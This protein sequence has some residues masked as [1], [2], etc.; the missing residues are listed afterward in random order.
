MP[1]RF[2]RAWLKLARAQ[3][4]AIA[5]RQG[6]DLEHILAAK[7]RLSLLLSQKLAIY[8][9]GDQSACLVKEILAEEEAA[10]EELV[11]WREKVAEEF[12]QLQKWR[13]LIQHQ[14][15]LAPVRNRLF[16]RRC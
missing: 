9:P 7:E 4:K 12:C 1:E 14:R 16:E 6:E 11:R 2:L 10:R 13:E 5:E 8:H 15:A 3:R